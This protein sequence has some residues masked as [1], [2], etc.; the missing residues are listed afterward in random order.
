MKNKKVLT[1]IAAALLAVSPI[2][3]TLT[4]Q[5]PSIAAAARRKPSR[6][7]RS[8]K[9]SRR[10]RRST[11]KRTNRRRRTNRRTARRIRKPAKKSG[12][13]DT[14]IAKLLLYDDEL[15]TDVAGNGNVDPAILKKMWAEGNDGKRA[16]IKK[17]GEKNYYKVLSM[18]SSLVPSKRCKR[19]LALEEK[20]AKEKGIYQYLN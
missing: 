11:R 9:R 16:W 5:A 20:M 14:A 12:L 15:G 19:C 1:V 13:S 2:A 3:G 10:R 4:S 17:Y 6:S 8:R 18:K 7:K